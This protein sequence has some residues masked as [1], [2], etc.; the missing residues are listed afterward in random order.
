MTE[1]TY[2]ILELVKFM[3]IYL[4]GFSMKMTKVLKRRIV[5]GCFTVFIGSLMNFLKLSPVYPVL[6]ILFALIVF[7]MLIE[8]LSY[9]NFMIVFWSI[10]VV[11][12]VDSISY[13]LVRLG[14][15]ITEYQ[16]SQYQNLYASCITLIILGIIFGVISHNQ[17]TALQDLS[18]WYFAA[19]LVICIVNA[20]VLAIIEK[21]LMNV[22]G[23]FTAVYV[24][25]VVSSLVQMAFVLVLASANNGHRK[26]EELKEQ[27]LELQTE[28]YQY[29]EER[30]LTTKKFRHDMRAHMYILKQYIYEKKWDELNH[31]I[32]T[33]C[34]EIEYMPGYLSL[35]NETVDAILNYYD[36]QFVK[37]NAIL[38]VIGS[39]PQECRIH[40]YDLCTIFFNILSN[41]LESIGTLEERHAVLSVHFDDDIIYIREENIYTGKLEK[42]GEK[43]VTTKADKELHGFGVQN[44]KD[45]VAKYKGMVS[46]MHTGQHFVMDILMDNI[47]PVG[48]FGRKFGEFNA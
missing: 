45:S 29:L 15:R 20:T 19:F 14:L 22:H 3:I 24:M 11:F 30:N 41:A 7:H 34:G 18:I 38:K 35:K 25:L 4:L 40:A 44:I 33:I 39:L 28:H 27:Y 36:S 9:R 42:N 6:C 23:E 10:G 46:I 12:S 16:L 8:R 26:N 2:Y 1:I 47:E 37:R 17:K 32:D 13:V 31:Y 43:L 48:K 5:A 21:N